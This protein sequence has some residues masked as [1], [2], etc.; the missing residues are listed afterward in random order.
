MPDENPFEDVP[1]EVPIGVM[2]VLMTAFVVGCL[3]SGYLVVTARV[4][5]QEIYKGFDGD[6]GAAVAACQS[7]LDGDSYFA[8]LLRG[9]P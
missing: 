6:I 9:R 4:D 8:R 7:W 1:M 3:D 2:M 5:G